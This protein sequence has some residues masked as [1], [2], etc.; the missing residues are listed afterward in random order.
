MHRSELQNL[1]LK[2]DQKTR[3]E[4]IRTYLADKIATARRCIYDLGLAIR[5]TAVEVLL[6]N[7][8][9]VP[10]ANAFVE[11]LGDNFNPS[12]IFTVDLLHEIELG[13]WKTLFTHLVRI[14]H[15][16]GDNLVATLDERYRSV[17]VFGSGG[18]GIR[19][20]SSNSSEMK[21][22]AARDFEDLLQCALPCFEALLPPPHDRRLMKLLYRF[23]EWHALA[24]LRMHSDSTLKLLGSLTNEIGHL[25]R[26]FRDDTCPSFSTMELPREAVARQ[27]HQ[28]SNQQAT[29]SVS[30]TPKSLNL[31]TVKF[32]FMGDYVAH[33]RYFGTTDSYSTQLG[34]QAHRTI[35]RL[36]SVTNKKNALSQIGN[37]YLRQQAFRSI[38]KQEI[39]GAEDPANTGRHY[40]ISH[41]TDEPINVYS[42]V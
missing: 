19:H 22:M 24:K 35:K 34:E 27:R 16:A 23:A 28:G 32:H 2:R 9:A 5:S 29:R 4:K 31:S 14:L 13:T 6:R 42:F 40:V 20:F 12:N 33:I 21:K 1:G 3:A 30:R 26:H 37:K 18:S 11:Q 17:P 8:S 7:I 15:S 25:L 39:H 10:T 38:E 41:I 36:Y